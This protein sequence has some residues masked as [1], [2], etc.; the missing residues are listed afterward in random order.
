LALAAAGDKSI[1]RVGW[2]LANWR[3][4]WKRRFESAVLYQTT[5]I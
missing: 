2:H 1:R 5:V 3:A 4:L